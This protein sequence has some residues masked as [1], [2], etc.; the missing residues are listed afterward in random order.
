MHHALDLANIVNR[1]DAGPSALTIGTERKLSDG[2]KDGHHK[3]DGKAENVLLVTHPGD[4][5]IQYIAWPI[6]S[7]TTGKEQG[8]DTKVGEEEELAS[9]GEDKKGDVNSAQEGVKA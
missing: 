7:E 4:V 8:Y 3:S 2:F 5:K 9:E 1:P 6:S